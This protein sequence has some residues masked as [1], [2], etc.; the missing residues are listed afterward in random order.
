[1]CIDYI[2]LNKAYPNDAYLLPLIDQ[3]ANAIADFEL[4]SFMATYYVYNQLWMHP[5]NEE[6]MV[7]YGEDAIYC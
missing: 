7:F 6:K 5:N 2:D 3:F 4:L 1:M